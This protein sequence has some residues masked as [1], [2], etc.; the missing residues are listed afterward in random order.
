VV[1]GEHRQLCRVVV[2]TRTVV[3]EQRHFD[4]VVVVTYSW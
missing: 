3:G 2:V 4:D 1:D